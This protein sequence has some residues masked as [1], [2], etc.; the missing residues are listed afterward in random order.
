MKIMIK[1]SVYLLTVF[2]LF[3]VGQAR[4]VDYELPDINGETQSLSQYKGK[5]L[6]VNYW[7]TWCSTCMKE[8]PELISLYENNKDKDIAVIGINYEAITKKDLKE[9]VENKSIPYSILRSMPVPVTPLGRVPALP[10][11]YIIDPQGKVVAGEI[12]IVSQKNI[13]SYILIKK[14]ESKLSPENHAANEEEKNKA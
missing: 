10:I 7:A 11:T 9:F 1:P 4:A 13:E 3:Y 2:L 6:I 8:L 14:Q 5:W 12:G